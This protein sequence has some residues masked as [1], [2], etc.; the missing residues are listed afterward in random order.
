MLNE[1]CRCRSIKY[2]VQIIGRYEYGKIEIHTDT[3][4]QIKADRYRQIQADR[5][6]HIK[7]NLPKITQLRKAVPKIPEGAECFKNVCNM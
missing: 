1:R 7:A 3:H 5:Y 2:R 4:R 6:R